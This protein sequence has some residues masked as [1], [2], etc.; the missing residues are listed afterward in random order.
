[1]EA[2]TVFENLRG[3]RALKLSN[4]RLGV[5]DTGINAG[6]GQPAKPEF[7]LKIV[8]VP[9][10]SNLGDPNGHGTQVASVMVAENNGVGINGVASRFLNAEASQ[11]RDR[12][13]LWVFQTPPGAVVEEDP[14][15]PTTMRGLVGFDQLAAAGVDVVNYSSSARGLTQYAAELG[16]EAW[17]RALQKWP[18]T[19]LVVA[20]PDAAVE[21]PR[22]GL[23]YP[24]GMSEPNLITVSQTTSCQPGLPTLWSDSA[25]G[26]GV[27]IYAPGQ[28]MWT[29]D[30]LDC[31]WHAASGSSLAAPL[32]SS[33]A[34]ILK[35]VMPS[36]T[37]AEIKARIIA[38]AGGTGDRNAA[39]QPD[40]KPR[41]LIGGPLLQALV[42]LGKAQINNILAADG[43][44]DSSGKLQPD[45][46]GFAVSRLCDG[47]VVNEIIG[48]G[49]QSFPIDEC[50]NTSI[51]AH[52]IVFAATN[53]S[54]TLGVMCPQC[55][56]NLKTFPLVWDPSIAGPGSATLDF[57]SGTGP[58]LV[59]GTS[60]DGGL[61][62]ASCRIDAR[63]HVDKDHPDF[64]TVIGRY[65]GTMRLS[66]PARDAAANGTFDISFRTGILDPD[67]P[68]YAYF[69][70]A[71]VGGV[72]RGYGLP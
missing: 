49:I 39:G 21:V 6:C 62:F 19:L 8:P 53:A 34:A 54:T 9:Y 55:D 15:K 26:A 23:W 63:E 24:S 28:N 22:K 10:T 16:R 61:R 35:S 67:D 3:R 7:N 13:S 36:L 12:V 27:D 25:R 33:L 58:G 69:E 4:V 59:Q 1:M 66:L 71:C 29:L 70:K 57:V 40:P 46:F 72:P 51:Q 47:G 11:S 38:G 5:I 48:A 65:G 45:G 17:H 44:R 20:T 60:W 50:R 52:M 14:S 68:L 56:F 18:N 43:H 30:G 37:P 41:L 64:V 42:D 2:L 31:S 32:V